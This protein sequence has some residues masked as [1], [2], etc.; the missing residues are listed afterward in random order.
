MT[1]TRR[2]PRHL[3]RLTYAAAVDEFDAYYTQVTGRSLSEGER[4]RQEAIQRGGEGAMPTERA[5]GGGGQVKVYIGDH[6]YVETEGPILKLSTDESD[7]AGYNL[8]CMTPEVWYTL[9]DWVMG[10]WGGEV[11]EELLARKQKGKK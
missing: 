9:V 5:P 6:T 3:K 2:P 7:V 1:V 10:E 11:F 4:L 8:I